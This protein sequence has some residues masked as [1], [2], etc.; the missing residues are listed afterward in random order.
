MS[1]DKSFSRQVKMMERVPERSLYRQ[2]RLLT[3]SLERKTMKGFTEVPKLGNAGNFAKELLWFFASV[4]IALLLALMMFYVVSHFLEGLLSLGIYVA[5]SV[6]NFFYL[7]V[8]VSFIGVYMVRLVN[9]A[10]KKLVI[11]Q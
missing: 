3:R 4:L 10:I 5:G 1:I 6:Y 9:W 8:V 7:L 2:T 11:K